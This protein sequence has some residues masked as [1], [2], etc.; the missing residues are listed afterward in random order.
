MVELITFELSSCVSQTF[1]SVSLLRGGYVRG[2]LFVEFEGIKPSLS[3]RSLARIISFLR[4]VK[5]LVFKEGR[6]SFFA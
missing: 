3:T 2:D 5:P 4:V 6:S 1:M